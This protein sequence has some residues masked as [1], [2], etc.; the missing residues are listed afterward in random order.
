MISQQG[1]NI[2]LQLESVQNSLKSVLIWPNLGLYCTKSSSEVSALL[3]N[4]PKV[5][6]MNEEMNHNLN[7]NQSTEMKSQFYCNKM[8]A[9]RSYMKIIVSKLWKGFDSI[10][11]QSGINILYINPSYSRI[12]IGSHLWSIR[13]QTH[14]WRQ[15]SLQVFLN[16]LLSIAT[17]QFASFCIDIRSL[18]CY[19]VSVKVA[20]FQIKSHFS[21]IF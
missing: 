10:S 4:L 7:S 5:Y 16:F 8:N 3:L 1:E 17:N 15:R 19:F 6:Y 21:R 9:Y 20:K 13:G 12:L 14:R 11:I 2:R 18:Q